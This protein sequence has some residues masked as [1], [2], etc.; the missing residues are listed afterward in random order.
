MRPAIESKLNELR[1]ILVGLWLRLNGVRIGAGCSF[2]RRVKVASGVVLGQGVSLHDGCEIHGFVRLGDRVVVQKYAEIAGNINVGLEAVIGSYS[3]VSTM[4]SGHIF[5]GERVLINSFNVIGAGEHVVI[6]N[7]CIFA[8]YVQITDSTHQFEHIEDS[9]RHDACSTK[10]VAIGQGTWLGS[11]VKVLMGV[12]IGQ[13]AVVGAN[14]VVI[15]NLPAMS[16]AV[17]APAAVVRTRCLRE[18]KKQ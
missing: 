7:D 10:P 6:H 8:P 15:K 4:P 18:I 13:G 9:P 17:G 16:V 2:G 1:S 11:G 3:I 12:Q 14:A 5:I